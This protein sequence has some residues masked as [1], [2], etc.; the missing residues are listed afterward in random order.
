[1]AGA[2]DIKRH[3]LQIRREQAERNREALEAAEQRRTDAEASRELSPAEQRRE[4]LR[5]QQEYR[6]QQAA[7]A[8]KRSGHRVDA[9][10]PSDLRSGVSITPSSSTG[11]SVS[12]NGDQQYDPDAVL[13]DVPFASPEARDLAIEYKMTGADFEPY[14][15]TGKTGYVVDD[16]DAIHQE[17]HPEMY[18]S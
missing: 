9:T 17:L 10:V 16:V 4:R 18:G 1:M 14:V 2:R 3:T 6:D 7:G 13:R 12:G 5:R 11:D 8:T 15:H